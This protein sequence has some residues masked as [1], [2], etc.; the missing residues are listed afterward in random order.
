MESNALTM[1]LAAKQQRRRALARLP[2]EEKLSAVMHLQRM[3]A[4]IMKKRGKTCRVWT[5]Q[6]PPDAKT[7]FQP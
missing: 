3:A 5:F 6:A 4:P 2:I 7:P 1:A